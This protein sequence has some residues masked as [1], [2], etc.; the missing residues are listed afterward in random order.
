V[1][2]QPT[3]HIFFDVFLELEKKSMINYL[4]F[5]SKCIHALLDDRNKPYFSREFPLFYKQANGESAID[6]ALEKN[7]IRS[8]NIMVEYILKYQNNYCYSNL[9][10]HNFVDLL[11][12]GCKCSDLLCSQIFNYE[13]DF[14][15]WPG[16]NSNTERQLKPFS[17]SIFNLRTSYNKIFEDIWRVDEEKD[18]KALAGNTFKKQSKTGIGKL[19]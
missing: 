11:N 6:D 16:T 15:H 14:D 19:G 12:K 1:K 7:Q 4:A 9:F 3:P 10:L 2:G 13:F 5:D 8:V 17:S 18:M